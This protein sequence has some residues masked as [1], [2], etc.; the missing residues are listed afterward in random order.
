M[1]N[2]KQPGNSEIIVLRSTYDRTQPTI[3][4]VVHRSTLLMEEHFT[5]SI[6]R[7]RSIIAYLIAF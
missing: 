3:I 1:V 5:V 2:G 6:M 7:T 4:V